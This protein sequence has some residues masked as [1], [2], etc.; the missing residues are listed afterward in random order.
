[1]E[2]T[3][4]YF[5]ARLC[6]CGVWLASA[7]YEVFH[8]QHTTIKMAQNHVPAPT[9]LLLPVIMMK[10]AGS[11]ML[12]AN[13]F[14]WAV[15]LA[16]IAFTIPATFL[17]HFTFHDKDGTFIFPQMIQFSKNVSILGGLL[18]LIL[19]D[20]NKPSWLVALLHKF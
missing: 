19:L 18:A 14:V 15:S 2:A 7:I 16:W 12:I 4:I 20:P 8:Y 6:T 10:L 3:G 13:Q 17:Y 1:M 11:L 9:Y 5:L